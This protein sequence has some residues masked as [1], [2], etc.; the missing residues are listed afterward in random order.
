MH[1]RDDGGDD[2]NRLAQ[3]VAEHHAVDR[4][5]APGDLVRPAGK[6]AEVRHRQRDIRR[7]RHSQRLAI[8]LQGVRG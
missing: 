5:G 8:V 7:P 1:V 3:G 2:A 6:V 4:D